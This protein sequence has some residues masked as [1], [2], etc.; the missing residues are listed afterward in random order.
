MKNY[1]YISIND[2][3]K[4]KKIK[5]S[6]A[7]PVNLFFYWWKTNFLKVWSRHLFLFI[8]KRKKIRNKTFYNSLFEKKK[9]K[10]TYLFSW[11]ILILENFLQTIP[12]KKILTNLLEKLFLWISLEI[13]F[14]KIYLQEGIFQFIY[15]RRDFLIILLKTRFTRINIKIC[16]EKCF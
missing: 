3:D 2:F 14:F 9:D 5:I 6:H 4:I 16:F 1:D 7:S 10:S 11:N 8:S 12:K 15:K 13:F